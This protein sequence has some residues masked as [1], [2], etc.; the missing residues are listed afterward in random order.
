MCKLESLIFLLL[1]NMHKLLCTD[2]TK[3]QR[4]VN[5]WS[6]QENQN[7]SDT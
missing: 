4:S 7:K 5:Q 2:G 3:Q 1:M 6:L